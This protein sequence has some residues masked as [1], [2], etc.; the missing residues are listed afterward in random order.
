MHNTA[1]QAPTVA[2]V[3]VGKVLIDKTLLN[4]ETFA[5]ET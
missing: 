4:R 1:L 2:R 5:D 3:I